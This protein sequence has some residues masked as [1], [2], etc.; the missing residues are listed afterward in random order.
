MVVLMR[1][2]GMCVYVR[3]QII[4]LFSG[5]PHSI[6]EDGA[7]HVLK[8][9]RSSF[10]MVLRKERERGNAEATRMANNFFFHNQKANAH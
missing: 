3:V 2:C 5:F 8:T 10:K 9:C 6:V 1:M 4:P 7:I